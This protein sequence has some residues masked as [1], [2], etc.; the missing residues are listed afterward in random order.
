MATIL[1]GGQAT[2]S[3]ARGCTATITPISGSVIVDRSFG[4]KVVQS[5]SGSFPV[6]LG[7]YHFD[8]SFKVTCLDGQAQIDM[9]SDLTKVGSALKSPLLS[10]AI[11]ARPAGVP[12]RYATL[13]NSIYAGVSGISVADQAAYAAG[14]VVRLIR[15]GGI[16]GNTSAMMLD[17]ISRDVPQDAE[18]CTFMEGANDGLT[19]VSVQSH[20]QNMEAIIQNLLGRGIVPVLDF[21]SPLTSNVTLA[22]AYLAAQQALVW[23]YGIS[24]FDQWGAVMDAAT[25][26]WA[27]GNSS[28]GVHPLFAPALVAKSAKAAWLR[29]GAPVQAWAP[30]SNVAGTANYCLAGGNCF[31][32]TDTNT[33]G[34]PDGWTKAGT[35]TASITTAP[36]GYRGS[37]ARLTGTTASGNPYLRKVVTSGWLP[38]DD[39]LISFAMESA[40]GN[41]TAGGSFLTVKVDG[42]ELNI[43]NGSVAD[44]SAQRMMFWVKP[45]TL[46]Q[47]EFYAKINGTGTGNYIGVGE[48]EIYNVTALLNR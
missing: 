37:F 27:A 45:T 19:G 10:Q 22:A 41:L 20:R 46:T 48:F 8:M 33:D 30:R 32:L 44:I 9:A 12:L 36:A 7:P 26:T 2:N 29:A 35:A 38:G 24:G 14:D 31:M 39:L 18:V 23:K 17:R 5:Q 1:A 15:S 3:L 4:D 42:A 25:G 40:A 21:T 34:V 6:V 16:A 13:G 28:D 43:L 11:S 47:L